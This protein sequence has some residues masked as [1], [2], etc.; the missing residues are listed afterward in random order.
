MSHKIFDNDLAVI[1]KDEF[2]LMLSKPAYSG[3]CILE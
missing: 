1:R 2:T 3:M